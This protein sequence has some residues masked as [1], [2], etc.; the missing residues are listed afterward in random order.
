M[1]TCIEHGASIEILI[2]AAADRPARC[3]ALRPSCYT[4]K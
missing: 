1:T 4:Q 2:S 3:A